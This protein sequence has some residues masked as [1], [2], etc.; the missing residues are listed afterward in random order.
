M[1]SISIIIPVYNDAARLEKTL[2]QLHTIRAQEY[3]NLE[4]V[5]SVRPSRDNTEEVARRLADVVVEGGQVSFARN[6]GARAAHGEVIVFLDCDAIPSF[7][8]IPAIAAVMQH[9]TIGTCTAYPS[10]TGLRPWIAVKVQNGARRTGLVK[11]LSNLLFCHRSIL[12]EQGIWYDT[13]LHLGEHRDFISRAIHLG[14]AQYTYIPL[15]KGYSVAVDRYDRI[16]YLTTF[17]FWVYWTWRT[18]ILRHPANEL[19]E[20]YWSLKEPA[21]PQAHPL[22][23]KKHFLSILRTDQRPRIALFAFAWGCVGIGFGVSLLAMNYVGLHGFLLQVFAEELLEDPNAP[24]IHLLLRVA[25]QASPATIAMVSG[26]VMGIHGLLVLKH[27][28][29]AWRSI[30][31]NA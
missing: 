10:R 16:G 30:R 11:G 8:T 2:L 19:Q 3:A 18:L 28:K 22:T 20:L 1:K 13:E 17:G 12:H 29:Q 5:V 6:Q 24:I 7:G 9:N 4:I 21:N 23:W 15:D 27:S 25:S 14:G 26:V 31:E